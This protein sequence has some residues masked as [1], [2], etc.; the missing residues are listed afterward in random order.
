MGK[1]FEKLVTFSFHHPSK[2]L[3]H[4]FR[5]YTLSIFKSNENSGFYWCSTRRCGICS[6]MV[7]ARDGVEG[8]I[9]EDRDGY[10]YGYVWYGGP[11]LGTGTHGTGVEAGTGTQGTGVG[12]RYG[13]IRVHMVRAQEQVRCSLVRLKKVVRGRNGEHL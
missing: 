2:A 8:R 6:Y 1:P 3:P 11:K 4:P 13:Y 7:G 9:A 12:T 5:N 10:R